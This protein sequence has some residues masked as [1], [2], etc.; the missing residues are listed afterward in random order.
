MTWKAYTYPVPSAGVWAGGE[1]CEG[2][3]SIR[4]GSEVAG[5]VE[6]FLFQCGDCDTFF[7]A[8]RWA[9]LEFLTP[10]FWVKVSSVEDPV[11]D[12]RHSNDGDD[13]H[14][15][16]PECHARLD[17]EN[18]LSGNPLVAFCTNSFG[19]NCLDVL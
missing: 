5:F 14:D 18:G 3:Q 10:L 11:G 19:T 15:R 9:T 12:Y 17:G 7:L 1:S 4:P 16:V 6:A 13:D 2:L 8:D